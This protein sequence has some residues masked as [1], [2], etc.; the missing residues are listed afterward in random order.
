MFIFLD[1]FGKKMAILGL[2]GDR[3]VYVKR[4]LIVLAILLFFLFILFFSLTIQTT[5]GIDKDIRKLSKDIKRLY[6]D[7][8]SDLG[9]NHTLPLLANLYWIQAN[10]SE[11]K[12]RLDDLEV[13]ENDL[14]DK[15]Q[16]RKDAQDARFGLIKRDVGLLEENLAEINRNFNVLKTQAD[17]N[18]QSFFSE[19]KK[20][21][22][23]FKEQIRNYSE[24]APKWLI[25]PKKERL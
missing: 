1:F 15:I 20:S 7:L 10:L 19:T 24:R 21:V 13:K 2:N 8:K 3:L 18:Q 17:L 11:P 12:R 14:E 9:P 16:K 23:S 5:K 22:V 6:A 4:I 25:F